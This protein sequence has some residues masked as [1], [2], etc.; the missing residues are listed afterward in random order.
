MANRSLWGAAPRAR[1]PPGSGKQ[2]SSEPTLG[3][4]AP[5]HH[6]G[7]LIC[8]KAPRRLLTRT[9]RS[10]RPRVLTFGLSDGV[11]QRNGFGGRL[12][13]RAGGLHGC[14]N[15]G[16]GPA[17]VVRA[18]AAVAGHGVARPHDRS[19]GRLTGVT[20]NRDRATMGCT[21]MPRRYA[22]SLPGPD[23]VVDALT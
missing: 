10:G 22:P 12:S 6:Q 20:R 19:T 7:R 4:V 14:R 23:P 1:A 2:W 18:G 21:A 13:P 17:L 8:R 16:S 15:S 9:A 11:L 3:L 5:D